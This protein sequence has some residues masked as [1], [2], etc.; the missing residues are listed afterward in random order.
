MNN[1]RCNLRIRRHAVHGIILSLSMILA[2]AADAATI[3]V[4]GIVATGTATV[5]NASVTF[6]DAG[7]TTRKI[8]TQTDANGEY[9][10]GMETAVASDLPTPAVFRLNQNYP[11]PFSA[12]TAITYELDRQT[13]VTVSIYDLL[14]REIIKFAPGVQSRG[15]HGVEWDGRDAGGGRMAAGVYFCRLNIDGAVQVRKML[16]HPGQTAL[17]GYHAGAPFSDPVGAYELLRMNLLQKAYYTVRI[18]N[19]QTTVPKITPTS[20]YNIAVDNDTTINFTIREAV[21]ANQADIQ[22]TSLHQLIRGFGASNIVGWRPDMTSGQVDLA[23]GTGA[24][25]LGFT[26]LRLRVPSDPSEFRLQVTTARLARNK[27][28]LIIASPWSPPASMK[29]NKNI[30]GGRLN[31][32]SYAS[33]AKYLASFADFM[34]GQ[35]VPLYAIS[36]QNEPDVTV[37]YESCDYDAVQMLRFV[38]ENAP[39]IGTRVMAPE[40]FHFARDLSDAILNDSLANANVPIIAG[41]IYGGGLE[42]YPLA[43]DRGKEIWMT[44]HLDTDVTWEH[45]LATGKEINDCMLAGMNAYVWWYIVRFYGPIDENGKVTQRGYV[46]SQFSRFIRPGYYRVQATENPQKQVYLSAYK[47][48]SQVVIVAINAGSKSVEQTFVLNGGAVSA[49]TPFVTSSQKNCFQ[50]SDVSVADGSFAAT[51]EASSVTT[52]VSQPQPGR[53]KTN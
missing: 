13:E 12:A 8:V 29:T 40:S 42:R 37:T 53:T 2:A 41:H 1:L 48:G 24:G 36:V 19:L 7:D 5:I 28:A 39:A 46:M 31:D 26:I 44:E 27:G 25:Q 21:P 52:F 47:D 49:F 10:I 45:V 20:Y 23:F 35:G 18:A 22:L 43:V 30:V 38:R 32:T 51:L 11:N 6:I 15:V 14:G 34:S 50:G 17:A 33:F 16:Y 4:S 3:R 9:V